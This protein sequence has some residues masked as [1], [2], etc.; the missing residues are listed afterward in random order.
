MATIVFVHGTGVRK[1]SYNESLVVIDNGLKK[2]LS[3]AGHGDLNLN[4]A[5]CLWGEAHGS[6]RAALCVPEYRKTG[7]K[8]TGFRLSEDN[9]LLWEMLGYNPLYELGGLALQPPPSGIVMKPD[10]GPIRSR[11]E[12]LP[13]EALAR[14]LAGAG[15]ADQFASARDYV[16]AQPDFAQ[17]LERSSS[18]AQCRTALARAIVAEA[19]DRAPAEPV[20]S[21]SIDPGLRDA[22]VEHL[23]DEISSPD[24]APPLEW[25]L[26]RLFRG[27]QRMGAMNLVRSRR[28]RLTDAAGPLSG[29]VLL[30]QS[31]GERIRGFIRNKVEQAASNRPVVLLAH[32]LGGIACVDLLVMEE[33]VPV[34]LLV[35]VG[36]QAPFLYEI[37]ALS[38]LDLG[39]PLPA[40]FVRRW[41][42]IYDPRDFLGYAARDV[43]PL[44]EGCR[45][46][47]VDHLVDNKLAFPDAHGGYWANRQT[48]DILAAELARA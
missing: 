9:V 48:W 19:M 4:V 8:E 24:K 30:Y 28:G 36:S 45:T 20:P 2:A 21:A 25:A 5:D 44:A 13:S 10:L 41:I 34:D 39:T 11:V 37:N 14:E 3:D 18:P 29:D 33:S 40:T 1:D 38:S 23:A 22:L 26:N 31:K 27:A 15:L 47:I 46:V 16:L 43:F 7:G 42:N 6:K 17:A 32:S 35:T 12:A